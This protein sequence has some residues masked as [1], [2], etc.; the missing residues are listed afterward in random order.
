[1]SLV[2]SQGILF[3]DIAVATTFEAP[4]IQLGR[5]WAVVM[6]SLPRTDKTSLGREMEHIP[7]SSVQSLH[8]VELE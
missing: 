6:P 3:Q 5:K 4:H 7:P 2:I 8:V 1:M